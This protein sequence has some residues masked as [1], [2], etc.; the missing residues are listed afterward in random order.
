MLYVTLLR[1]PPVLALWSAQTLSVLG[2][3]FFALAVM[4]L[5]LERSGPVAMG[6]V[7]I[8]ESVPY[9]LMGTIGRRVVDRLASFRGL[10]GLDLVRGVLTALLPWLWS[11]GGTTAML[12]VVL[13]LGVAG[14]WTSQ[15]AS[16]ASQVQ[17]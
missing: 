9:I 2:D 16:P 6:L 11:A 8:A 7:A 4:W 3:R 10:A 13:A 5:A 1:R 17:G 15:A 14:L 12:A